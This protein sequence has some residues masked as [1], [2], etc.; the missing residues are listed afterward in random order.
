VK[1]TVERMPNSE[2]VLNVEL[3]W[4]ELE[5]ASDNAYR[6]LV[7]KYNVPGFRRGRAPRTVLERLL[8]RETIY[9]EGLETLVNESYT[10]AM[11][12][13]QLVPLARP[14]VDIPPIV[15]GQ[16]YRFKATVPVLSPVELGDYH[17]LHFDLEVPEVTEA[18]VEEELKKIQDENAIWI[19]I[20]RP[21]A[22]GDRITADLQVQV[23]DRTVSNLKDNEFDLVASREGLFAGMDE[24]IV[25]MSEGETRE[26]TTTIPQDYLN[27][28]LAGKEAH[29]QVT[30]QSARYKEVPA[31]D[32]DLARTTGNY[33]SLDQLRASVRQRLEQRK[34][35]EAVSALRD[36]AVDAV[37]EQAVV[38]I[39]PVLVDE[40]V[41]EMID[42][43]RRM[44]GQQRLSLDFF[45]QVQQKTEQSYREELRPQALKQVKTDLVLEAVADQ[46]GI[47]TSD[48][49]I[50]EQL[51]LLAQGTGQRAARVAQ[52][53]AEQRR[54]I[55]RYLRRD[56]TIKRLVELI[57]PEALTQA[58]AAMAAEIGEPL[59][60]GD[61]PTRETA[62]SSADVAEPAN[63]E[64]R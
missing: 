54:R 29:Y 39:H 1:V 4:Q 41:T 25:G 36:K 47:M 14:D 27:Q 22:I 2:A 63:S 51:D 26:F 46:E 9:Q 49:E 15:F 10:Q 23:E 38:E 13:N 40:K 11:R 44:L 43:T 37:V 6:Q 62:D 35:Y 12:D 5:K 24:H 33:D 28:N 18:E 20:E 48:A 53:S 34:R 8:G 56:R 32:D 52:L 50:Q 45:L 58:N 17:A 64:T 55:L 7:Q 60:E 21:V 57:A 59:A 19:P 30:L 61:E 42:E 31:L 3:E 16:P